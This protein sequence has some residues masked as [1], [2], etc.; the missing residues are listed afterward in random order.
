MVLTGGAEEQ[1]AVQLEMSMWMRGKGDE[2][3]FKGNVVRRRG[4]ERSFGG[5]VNQ[6]T[7]FSNYLDRRGGYGF[8]PLFYFLFSL[9]MKFGAEV[10]KNSPFQGQ[11]VGKEVTKTVFGTM[12]SGKE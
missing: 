6:E 1:A 9:T 4:D 8:L 10:K 5:H 12:R 11:V 3:F 2:T 7:I